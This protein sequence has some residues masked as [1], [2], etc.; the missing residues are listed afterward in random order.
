MVCWSSEDTG[1]CSAANYHSGTGS[2]GVYT[3]QLVL[4]NGIVCRMMD[5]EGRGMV[6]VC[7]RVDGAVDRAVWKYMHTKLAVIAKLYEKK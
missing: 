4:W 2:R 7:A 6:C 5:G 3:L 1:G